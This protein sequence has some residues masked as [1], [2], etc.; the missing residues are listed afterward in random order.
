MQIHACVTYFTCKTTNRGWPLKCAHTLTHPYFFFKKT[1]TSKV[2]A[3]FR[4]PLT[5]VEHYCIVEKRCTVVTCDFCFETLFIRFF[6]YIPSKFKNQIKSK[7]VGSSMYFPVQKVRGLSKMSGD[8][9]QK[10]TTFADLGLDARLVKQS[11]L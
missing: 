11:A 9:I 2:S 3:H 6:P 8:W 4:R 1:Q 10:S 5:F 7:L